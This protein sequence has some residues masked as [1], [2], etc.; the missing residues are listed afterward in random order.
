MQLLQC[1]K[2]KRGRGDRQAKIN[3]SNELRQ[4]VHDKARVL[5]FKVGK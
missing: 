3:Y 4:E 2:L 1:V 5:R